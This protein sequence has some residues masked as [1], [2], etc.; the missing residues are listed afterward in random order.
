MAISNACDVSIQLIYLLIICRKM[1]LFP[2]KG[3]LFWPT[4][5]SVLL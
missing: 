1:C 4:L 2:M 5:V 3:M